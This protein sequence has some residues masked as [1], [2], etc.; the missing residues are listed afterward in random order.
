MEALLA[1]QSP[2]FRRVPSQC[3]HYHRGKPT[4]VDHFLITSRSTELPAARAVSTHGYCGALACR[5]AKPLPAAYDKLSDHCPI[6]V[7]LDMR[8]D[9]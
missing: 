6:V 4:S 1:T 3:S 8:D 5:P 2:P 9:D 7:E